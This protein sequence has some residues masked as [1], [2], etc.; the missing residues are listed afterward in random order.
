[1]TALPRSNHE[2]REVR[3]IVFDVKRLIAHEPLE[4]AAA[5][6]FWFF[7]SMVPLLVLG[8]YVVGQVARTRGV[9]ALVGPLLEVVPA[10]AEDIIR[11]AVERL[12]GGDGAGI[13][14]LGIAGFLW[15]S[16]SGLHNLMD[17]FE[18]TARSKPRAWWK[19]RAIALAGVVLGLV[20]ASLLALLLAAIDSGFHDHARHGA[21]R[22]LASPRHR[23]SRAFGAAAE[24]AIAAGLALAT[25]TALLA[26]FYRVAVERD[27]RAPCSVWP[28]AIVAVG[29]WLAVSWAFG[30][31]AVSIADYA[32]YYGGL[33]AVAVLL[34]WLYLT[35]LSLA[36]GA[37]VNAQ[38]ERAG[39]SASAARRRK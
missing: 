37:E 5:V 38:I 30:A 19:Q 28:G 14:P 6:A 36:I 21:A 4:A 39:A 8:G 24:Q 12:A 23:T 20:V 15:T 3:S 29:S 31:Y 33:A 7:L 16:S 13:A 10:S 35:S 2:L 25:G 32:V 18:K 34:V 22:V 11:K 9:D 17:A 26:G 27:A 1:M